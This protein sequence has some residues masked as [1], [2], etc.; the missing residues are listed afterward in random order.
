MK[1][2]KVLKEDEIPRSE[3]I[4]TFTGGEQRTNANSA[5]VSNTIRPNPMDV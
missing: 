3:S 4:Q 5:A 1:Y 2:E